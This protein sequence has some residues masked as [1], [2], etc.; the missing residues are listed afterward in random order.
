MTEVDA[1]DEEAIARAMGFGGFD[2]TKGR[3][4]V[5]NATGAVDKKKKKTEYRQILHRKKLYEVP[6][7]RQQAEEK[8]QISPPE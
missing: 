2:T 1:D 7:T 5:G 4:V 6:L 8:Q 3:H